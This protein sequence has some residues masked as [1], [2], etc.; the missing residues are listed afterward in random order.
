MWWGTAAR[1]KC[2]DLAAERFRGEAVF[3]RGRDR[4]EF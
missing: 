2:D 4:E 3:G 1:I